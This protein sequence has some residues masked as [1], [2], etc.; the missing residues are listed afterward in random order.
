MKV[1]AYTSPPRGHLYPLVPILDELAR[2]GH[3]IVVRTLASQ[4]P[5]FG[6]DQLDLARRVEVADAGTRLP[7]QR[8]NPDRL[9]AKVREAMGNAAGARMV[10]DGFNATG[11]PVTAADAFEALAAQHNAPG[12]SEQPG[13]LAGSV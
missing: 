8:L 9:R 7:A 2:R 4:V 11:G 3:T 10:A 5:L 6:R 12:R 1:L 13:T